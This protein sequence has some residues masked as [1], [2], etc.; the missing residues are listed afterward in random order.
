MDAAVAEALLGEFWELGDLHAHKVGIARRARMGDFRGRSVVF[1][2]GGAR[3]SCDDERLGL[4]L[5]HMGAQEVSTMGAYMGGVRASFGDRRRRFGATTSGSAC[6][7]AIDELSGHALNQ[8]LSGNAPEAE[9][10]ALQ[11]ERASRAARLARLAS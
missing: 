9:Q 2:R 4:R 1:D 5:M 8:G 6:P 11:H 10:K 3:S 7:A